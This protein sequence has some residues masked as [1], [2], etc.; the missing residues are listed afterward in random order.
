MSEFST[1]LRL[2]ASFAQVDEQKILSMLKNHWSAR[3]KELT[4][5][6]TGL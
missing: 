4:L 5:H 3:K 2:V 6:S 1:S